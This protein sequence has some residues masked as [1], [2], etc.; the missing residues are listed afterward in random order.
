MMGACCTR[1]SIIHLVVNKFPLSG[2][3]SARHSRFPRSS[4]SS[5]CAT[6][7][8]CHHL[9]VSMRQ[10]FT[11]NIAPFKLFKQRLG[12]PSSAP[13]V[14]PRQ[15]GTSVTHLHLPTFLAINLQ[16]VAADICGSARAWLP[17]RGLLWF[18]LSWPF[19]ATRAS[20]KLSQKH[21]NAEA[22]IHSMA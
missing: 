14:L 9:V 15:A 17:R 16:Y 1:V 4:D 2:G 6:P 3:T 20:H 22:S 10:S 18:Q 21:A 13:C 7:R 11:R 12:Q 8:E 19:Y 5:K